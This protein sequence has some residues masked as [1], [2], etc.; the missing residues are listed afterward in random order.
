MEG[1]HAC[2]AGVMLVA[3]GFEAGAVASLP[4]QELQH[5]HHAG[6]PLGHAIVH[7]GNA[8]LP[9]SWGCDSAKFPMLPEGSMLASQQYACVAVH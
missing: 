5:A 2:G 3:G 8:T 4:G 1:D 6:W 7:L 9:C